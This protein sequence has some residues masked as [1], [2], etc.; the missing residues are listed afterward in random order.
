MN[1]YSLFPLIAT[2]AYIPLLVTTISSRPWQRRYTLFILFL[3][4]AMVWSLLDYFFRSNFFPEYNLTIWRA[5]LAAFPLMAV[6]FHCFASSF[7]AQGQRRWLPFAYASLAAIVILTALGYIGEGFIAEGDKF[8]PSYGI[9]II[10]MAAPLLTLAGR[11]FYV[12]GKMLRVLDNPVLYNQIFSLYLGLAV[13]VIFGLSAVIPWGNEFPFSHFGNLINAFILSYAT[14]RHRLVDIKIILRRGSAFAMLA[15]IGGVSYW[16]L[17][18]TFHVIFDFELDTTATF[19]A[20]VIAVA[21]AAFVYRLRGVLFT[22]TG[23]AFQGQTYDYRQLLSEFAGKIHNIFSLREQGRELL[24][25]LTGAIDCRKSGLLFLDT[26]G[27]AFNTQLVEPK[28]K[29]NPLSRLALR[30]HNPIVEYLERERKLLTRE[31]L[32]IMPEFR[33]LWQQEKA[34]IDSAGI[35]L[36]VP[37]ISRDRLIAIL[38][39]D[40]KKSGRYSLEDFNL[41]ES[42][43]SQVAVSM[44]K[45]YLREQLKEREEELS[46]INRLSS[47]ITSSLDIQGIFDSFIE[48]LKK[49]V[50]VSWAAIALIEENDRYILA[51]SS[52]S[53][54][55]W[56]TEERMPVAGTVTEWV[57]RNR[58]TLY[59]PD[60]SEESKFTTGK[61][62]L[63][64][65]LRSVICLPLVAKGEAIG[66]LIITNHNPNAYS[67]RDAALLEQLSSQIAMPVEN[68]RLYAKAEEKARIDVLTGLNNRR[69]LD[70]MIAQEI[71]RHSRYGGIFSVIILDLDSFKIFNDK[72]G[73]L[74]GDKLLREIGGIIKGAIRGADQA[75]RYGGDEFAVLLPQTAIDAAT[76]VAERVRQHIA[77]KVKAGSVPITASLGLASWPADGI[78]PDEMLSAADA[79]LYRAKRSGGNQIQCSSGT[80][81]HLGD[82]GVSFWS[83]NDSGALSAIYALAATV[84]ARDHYTGSHSKKVSK[85]AVVLAEALAMGALEIS[86]LE[87][88]ALLHDIGKIGVSDEILGKQGKLNDDEWD[89]IKTHPQLGS[90][91]ASRSRQLAPYVPGILHHHE[92][93]DGTGYPHGLKGEDIPLEA[94]ILAVADAFAAMTSDRVYSKALPQEEALEEIKQ[95]VGKQFDPHLA[96]I[97]ISTIQKQP[98]SNPETEREE[99]K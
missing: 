63:A 85:Y 98:Q 7:Y 22:A 49:V 95:G 96:E 10:F 71:G 92:R 19:I 3:I 66:S 53:I 21:I 42:I 62:Y 73:H 32:E 41:L 57:A 64:H 76:Q 1:I 81:L 2:I 8:Y 56:Q 69:S 67:Q 15:I 47:I 82:L 84:D 54:S 93:Y 36:F 39:L 17:L 61:L 77:T 78:G 48:E 90:T 6:Q 25:L 50:D 89:I 23:R 99:V 79:A 51:Q 72:Y 26:D 83:N 70:E 44:E 52:S 59:E 60:L 14:V 11:S 45:E 58:M 27:K 28:G 80:L 13:L 5:T 68:A 18:A 97:F 34:E 30:E 46:V 12:F 40:R 4:S 38:V 74:S 88:C 35:E 86:Q 55:A 87:T 33:S 31:N 75:F 37:L 16:I 20:T 9:G 65:G 24:A 94:R 29:D 91:I 43:A